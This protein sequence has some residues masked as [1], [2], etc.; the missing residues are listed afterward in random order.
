MIVIYVMAI[1]PP[2]PQHR[3]SGMFIHA[4]CDKSHATNSIIVASPV[5]AVCSW[6]M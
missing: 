4:N 5:R 1:L 3:Y 6:V 2:S